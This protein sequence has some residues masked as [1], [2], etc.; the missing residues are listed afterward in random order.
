MSRWS[1]LGLGPFATYGIACAGHPHRHELLVPCLHRE[2]LDHD[3]Q[4]HKPISDIRSNTCSEAAIC[5]KGSKVLQLRSS[6]GRAFHPPV[7][8]PQRYA[9]DRPFYCHLRFA[10]QCIMQR[11]AI[12][13]VYCLSPFISTRSRGSLPTSRP[14]RYSQQ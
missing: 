4:T 7:A 6:T 2:L 3:A 14:Q 8:P 10:D 13:L 9:F 5:L 12:L 11:Y 1:A